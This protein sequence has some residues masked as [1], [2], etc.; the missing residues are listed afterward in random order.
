MNDLTTKLAEAL[1]W[2]LS[3]PD[4]KI[5]SPQREKAREALRLYDAAQAQRC[6]CGLKPASECEPWEPGCDLGQSPEHVR[7]HEAKAQPV[8]AL[9][10]L[11]EPA[12]YRHREEIGP[13]WS[14]TADQMRDYARA[15]LAATPAPSAE[16]QAAHD[17]AILEQGIQ[18]GRTRERQLWEHRAATPA[19][20]PGWKL[21]PVEPTPEMVKALKAKIIVGNQGGVMGVASA[22]RAMLAAAPEAGLK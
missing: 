18:V 6:Q 20:A 16:D 10:P 14:Y 4:C 7:V 2:I 21:V 8:Q 13:A 19:P 1:Q 9:P 11:P 22:Y 5:T 17:N 12:A 15:A 3:V